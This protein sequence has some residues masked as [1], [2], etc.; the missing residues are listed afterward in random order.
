MIGLP[1]TASASEIEA[2]QKELSRKRR[3][4]KVNLP[5]TADWDAILKAEDIKE[6]QD[7]RSKKR[8]N[9]PHFL[10]NELGLEQKANWRQILQALR[11]KKI[12]WDKLRSHLI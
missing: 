5:E 12:T 10:K 3:A 9:L 4:T 2:A 11:A 1:K 7:N 8:K 6:I